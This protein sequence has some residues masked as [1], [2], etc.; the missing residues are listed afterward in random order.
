MDR[1]F[2]KKVLGK[3]R[4]GSDVKMSIRE[5]LESFDR[6]E[7]EIAWEVLTKGELLSSDAQTLLYATVLSKKMDL[8]A[9][10][11]EKLIRGE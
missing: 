5:K 3:D 1:Q 9:E 2:I 4:K 11:M 6:K 10:K 8:R 7:Q